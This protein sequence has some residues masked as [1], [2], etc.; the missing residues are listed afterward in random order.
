LF[1]VL[2][3]LQTGKVARIPVVLVGR[4]FWARAVNFEFLV[5]QGMILADDLKLLTVVET[6]DEALAVLVDFYREQSP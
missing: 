5:D 6:A 2:T 1:E 4:E 3:L